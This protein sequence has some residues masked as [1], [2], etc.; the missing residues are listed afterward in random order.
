MR[1]TIYNYLNISNMEIRL[2]GGLHV[3]NFSF[4]AGYVR[5]R[6]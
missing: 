2:A 6:R 5:I 1:F 3:G 4:L